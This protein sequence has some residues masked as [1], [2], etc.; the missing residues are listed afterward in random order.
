MVIDMVARRITLRARWIA[1][2]NRLMIRGSQSCAICQ[3]FRAGH[4]APGPY[5]FTGA[6]YRRDCASVSGSLRLVDVGISTLH[7]RYHPFNSDCRM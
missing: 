2:L 4:T 1:L 6:R 7:R 3:V 5:H